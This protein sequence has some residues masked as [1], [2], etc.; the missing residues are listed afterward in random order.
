G[1]RSGQAEDAARDRAQ[2]GLQIAYWFSVRSNA[3][4]AATRRGFSFS[5]VPS[6]RRSPSLLMRGDLRHHAPDVLH[7]GIERGLSQSLDVAVGAVV[8][9]VRFRRGGANAIGLNALGA[10][11]GLIAGS[12][13]HGWQHGGVGIN[14]LGYSLHHAKH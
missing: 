8:E 10:Q 12:S 1:W 9:V 4:P 7:E 13:G 3:S 6:G 11:L 14:G 2:D 5:D